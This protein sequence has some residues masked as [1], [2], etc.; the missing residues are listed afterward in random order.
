MEIRKLAQLY[1]VKLNIIFIC[2]G[3]GFKRNEN[4]SGSSSITIINKS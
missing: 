3:Q 4:Y 1:A 2:V